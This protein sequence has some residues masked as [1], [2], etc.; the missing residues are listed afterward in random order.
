MQGQSARFDNGK[1]G[2]AKTWNLIFKE[3]AFAPRRAVEN[4]FT[5]ELP[6]NPLDLLL[7]NTQDFDRLLEFWMSEEGEAWVG[8][9]DLYKVDQP[10]GFQEMG[11]SPLRI[12]VQRIMRR[13][14]IYLLLLKTQE[15]GFGHNIDGR[16][17]ILNEWTPWPLRDD[18]RRKMY[19]RIRI[20]KKS[21]PA[22]T[23]RPSRDTRVRILK[24]S[25]PAGTPRPSRDSRVRILKKSYPAGTPRPSRDT[26]VRILKKSDPAGT[27][28]P[29]RGTRIRILKKSDP[30]GAPRPLWD[31]RVRILKK[32]DPAGA[33]RPSRDTRVRI[34]KKSDPAGSPRPSRYTRIRILKKSDPGGT[35]RPSRDTR[36]RIMKK[37]DPAG[38]PRPSRDSFGRKIG[39]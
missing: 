23:P 11:Y 5:A 29:S 4:H 21:D 15:D 24:K 9:L 13:S 20:L 6:L 17:K 18:S 10:V 8:Q 33:P 39:F 2:G 7:L 27:P 32:S 38:T 34:L 28:R 26:R 37:S 22:G 14:E 3:E 35:P 12:P 36:I 1:T 16:I 19:P 25:D 31:S 30:A